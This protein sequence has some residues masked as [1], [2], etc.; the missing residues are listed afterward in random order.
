MLFKGLLAT[1]MSG[2]IAGIVASHNKGGSYFRERIVPTNP[3]SVF[4]QAV[5]NAVSQLSSMWQSSLTQTQR[6][7][8]DVYADNV[9]ITNR[10]GDQVNISAL[11]HYIRSNVA[12]LVNGLAR[13]DDGPT[14][15][16]LGAYSAPNI[17]D[18]SEATQAGNFN[19][20]TGPFTDPWANEVGGFL[21]LYMSRP[22]NSGIQ[23]FRGPYRLVG[24]VTGDPVP[25]ASPAVVNAPFPFV[26]GQRLFGRA[27][28][29]TADGRYSTS[30]FFTTLAVA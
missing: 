21:W 6:D 7:E 16:N 12:R 11:A 22:Q 26:E 1:D 25:P 24:P 3:N 17:S 8:W 18:F 5:R 29:A 14:T 10:I 15:F 13:V 20:V 4:Q 9:T 2:A 19:F 28:A 30:S 23:Y 27:V